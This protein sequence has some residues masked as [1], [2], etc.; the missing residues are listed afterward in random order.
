MIF[1]DILFWWSHTKIKIQMIYFYLFIRG[2][3]FP[4]ELAPS[5]DGSKEIWG[6]QT[7][8]VGPLFALPT[9]GVTWAAQQFAREASHS[10]LHTSWPAASGDHIPNGSHFRG[11]FPATWNGIIRWNPNPATIRHLISFV[12]RWW[13][14]RLRMTRV[15][16]WKSLELVGHLPGQILIHGQGPGPGDAVTH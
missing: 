6:R 12:Y 16:P 5:A 9:T 7:P 14:T 13:M 11:F 1:N 4:L 2:L 8:S 3:V 15:Q 10:H